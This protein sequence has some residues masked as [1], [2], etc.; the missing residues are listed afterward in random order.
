M[1]PENILQD[2]LNAISDVDRPKTNAIIDKALSEGILP[3]DIVFQMIIPGI[4]KMIR[5]FIQDR[6]VALSRHFV[7]TTI[8]NEI[9]DRLLPLFKV[10]PGNR[11]HIVIGNAAGD[12]HGL[13]K[14]IVIGCLQSNMFTVTDV[15]L[16]ASAEA[17]VNKAVEENAAIIGVSSMMVHT[18]MGEGGPIKVRELLNERKL[19]GSIHL[20]VGGAPYQFDPLLYTKVGADAWGRDGIEAVKICG[21]LTGHKEAL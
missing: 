6:D 11:G 20:I 12:F 13:G 10:K 15:G 7:S 21:E 14:K 1:I 17:L 16:N 18:A 3:E 2:Y 5:G 8:A 19:S 9:V 4:E